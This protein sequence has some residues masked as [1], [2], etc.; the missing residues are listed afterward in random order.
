M[1]DCTISLIQQTSDSFYHPD[2]CRIT[3]Q[4][5]WFYCLPLLSKM[6][7]LAYIPQA[8]EVMHNVTP[9]FIFET[10]V[11]FARC[12]LRHDHLLYTS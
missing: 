4:L 8:C 3:G 10:K 2:C 9:S 12:R 11:Q 6:H 1:H 5:G 7:S